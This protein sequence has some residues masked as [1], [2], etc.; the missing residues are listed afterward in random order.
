[1][2]GLCGGYQM[3]GSTISDDVESRAG[4][5]AGLGLLPVSVRF[6]ADKTL[7][8]PSGSAYGAAVEGYEIHHG[9]ATVSGGEP[10]L[11]G[12]RVG[13]VFGTTWHGILENDDFRRA[14][15]TDVAATT[16]RRFTVSASTSFA[17]TRERRLEAL[18]DL[19]VD[20]LDTTA[21]RRLIDSGAP[22]GLPNVTPALIGSG[23]P[24]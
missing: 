20:H 5:V 9:V 7:G 16:G 22:S 15:L 3:L 18:G 12:C 14:F 4:E 19:V 1:V 24:E 6:A 13:S 23:A 10:F 21:L 17:A 11:D 2:V 8:R